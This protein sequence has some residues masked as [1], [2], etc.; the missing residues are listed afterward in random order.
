MLW[1]KMNA[2][3]RRHH[4]TTLK[5]MYISQCKL[6]VYTSQYLMELVP[7]TRGF[8]TWTVGV[9]EVTMYRRAVLSIIDVTSEHHKAQ[10]VLR[11]SQPLQHFQCL[12][13]HQSTFKKLR[14]AKF[15]AVFNIK[16]CSM[17]ELKHSFYIKHI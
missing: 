2:L 4:D 7:C 15:Y 16:C 9:L 17:A 14:E 6:L 8:S 10:P 3:L 5:Q 12:R 1:V 11:L 13:S